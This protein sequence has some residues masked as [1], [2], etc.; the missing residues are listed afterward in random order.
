[1]DEDSFYAA[2]YDD[3]EVPEDDYRAIRRAVLDLPSKLQ[4]FT[5]F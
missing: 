2:M 1:L 3:F 4:Q 5:M